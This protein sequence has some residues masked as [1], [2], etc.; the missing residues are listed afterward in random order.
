MTHSFFPVHLHGA[1]GRRALL[2]AGGLLV[3]GSITPLFNAVWQLGD[4]YDVPWPQRMSHYDTLIRVGVGVNVF[5]WLAWVVIART[6]LDRVSPRKR[7]L[8]RC[9]AVGSGAIALCAADPDRGL[10]FVGT[11]A[12]GVTF[13]WLAL[14]VCR[15]HGITLEKTSREEDPGRR[16]A[17]TWLLGEK[18]FYACAAGGVL[19]YLGMQALRVLDVAALPVMEGDQLA[20]IGVTGVFDFVAKLVVVVAVEDVIIV[21]ATAALM[22]AAGRPIWQ[23]YT[24]V[25]VVEVTVHAYFGLPAI[26]MA[27]FAAGRLRLFLRYGRVLPLAIAHAVFDLLGGFLMRVPFPER[28]LFI[29][30]L[31]VVVT[32]IAERVRRAGDPAEPIDPSA[33]RRQGGAPVKALRGI[34]KAIA[35]CESCANAERS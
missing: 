31:G 24:T 26:A 27:I 25:C 23:I 32:L 5:F 15:S 29:V 30:P 17:H 16:R 18:A 19:A 6:T 8:H 3:L 12:T 34:R 28:F 10:G 2:Q 1:A 21:A 22:T 4:L 9:A 33:R 13:A 35:H 7:M 14:E 20:T 11:V